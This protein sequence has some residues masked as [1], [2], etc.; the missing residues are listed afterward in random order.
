MLEPIEDN[1]HAEVAGLCIVELLRIQNGAPSLE[2]KTSDSRYDAWSIRT[3]QSEDH[4]TIGHNSDRQT[5]ASR[6]YVDQ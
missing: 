5:A 3:R 2:Q 6:K 4:G 1:A